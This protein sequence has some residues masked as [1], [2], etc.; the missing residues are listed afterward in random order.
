MQVKKGS[1]VGE[2]DS[3]LSACY[4]FLILMRSS[5]LYVLGVTVL[6][7]LLAWC[8]GET[9]LPTQRIRV[10]EPDIDR[11]STGFDPIAG[12]DF[13]GDMKPDVIVGTAAGRGYVLQIQFSTRIPSA[14]LAFEGVGPGMRVLSRDVN[15]DNDADLIVTSC[16]SLIPIAVFLGDGRGHFQPDNPWN[17]IPVGLN[18]PHSYD[19]PT[20]HEGPAS[21]TTEDRRLS[22]NALC[23]GLSVLKLDL[24]A[25]TAHGTK[26]PAVQTAGFVRSLRGPP[27]PL[28]I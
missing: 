26:G 19:S 3:P 24:R 6:V 23:R 7:S 28:S 12:A 17:Y 13:D 21:N 8:V 14:S 25:L 20:N 16:T 15:R 27:A 2:I 4:L 11:I 18:S 9:G 5:W 1:R 10:A 22:A